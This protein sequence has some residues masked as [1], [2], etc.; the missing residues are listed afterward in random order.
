MGTNEC[1]GCI[2]DIEDKKEYTEKIISTI[3]DNCSC[4]KRGVIEEY[5]NK[6]SDL[7]TTEEE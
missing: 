2:Y 7:Y 6:F 3:I 4:C 1:K 5:Q